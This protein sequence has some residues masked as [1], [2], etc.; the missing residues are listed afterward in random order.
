MREQRSLGRPAVTARF[1][2]RDMNTN[3]RSMKNC[4]GDTYEEN[5]SEGSSDMLSNR[6]E[7]YVSPFARTL[8]LVRR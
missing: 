7:A 2:S 3:I 4:T 1:Q 6:E 5:A 8:R